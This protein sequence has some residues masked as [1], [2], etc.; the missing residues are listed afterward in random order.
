MELVFY[1]IN[2]WWN[3]CTIAGNL[4]Q[5]IYKLPVLVCNRNVCSSNTGYTTRSYT[6]RCN[7]PVV[8]PPASGN[9]LGYIKMS[10]S[11][12][13]ACNDASTSGRIAVYGAGIANGNILIQMLL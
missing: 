3:S 12:I 6:T 5:W 7:A 8:T 2:Y 4:S 11:A 10:T 1:Y 9:L 13:N